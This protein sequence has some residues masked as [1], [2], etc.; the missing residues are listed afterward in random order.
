MSSFKRLVSSPAMSFAE[1]MRAMIF[2]STTSR[3]LVAALG[4][5]GGGRLDSSRPWR[6][7]LPRVPSDPPR[8]PSHSLLTKDTATLKPAN[9]TSTA[10]KTEEEEEDGKVKEEFSQLP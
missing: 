3:G 6:R 4:R 2:P 9:T 7:V 1:C 5:D 8:S 10:S